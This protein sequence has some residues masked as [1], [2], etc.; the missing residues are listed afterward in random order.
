MSLTNWKYRL[1]LFFALSDNKLNYLSLTRL[2]KL[3]TEE[4]LSSVFS[5][6]FYTRDYKNGLGLRE[7]SRDMMQWLM[8]NFPLEFIKII[9]RIPYYGR[10]D[11]LYSLFPGKINLDGETEEI[12]VEFINRNFCSNICSSDLVNIKLCQKKIID[13]FVNQLTIDL[14]DMW[15]GKEISL[16][17]KWASSEGKSGDLNYGFAKT[18]YTN[19]NIS[20]RDYRK[21]LSSLRGSLNI[22]E[23]YTCKK[24]WKEIDYDCVPTCAKQKLNKAFLKHDYIRYRKF[25]KKCCRNKPKNL[26]EITPSDLVSYYSDININRITLSQLKHCSNPYVESVWEN[27]IPKNKGSNVVVLSTSGSF[28]TNHRKNLHI[29]TAIGLI[30]AKK[31]ESP[32]SNCIISHNSDLE[33]INVG[34]LLLGGIKSISN[35]QD[36]SS[37]D[38]VQLFQL[39]GSQNRQIIV[40]S[41]LE[42]SYS[43]KQLKELTEIRQIWG[44]RCPRLVYINL[45]SDKIE[46][47][48]I[49]DFITVVNGFLD[50]T[51]F[52]REL[53]ETDRFN[54]VNIVESKINAY[55]VKF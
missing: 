9:P 55:N 15:N 19:L 28:Y 18:M 23:N 29:A 47:I 38:L 12:I 39:V 48:E 42:F 16:A 45:N 26:E 24:L 40:V 25:I 1:E 2:L 4:D 43:N 20:P 27:L 46:F 41:H 17:S 22:V 51:E 30:L 32:F 5:L 11:D 31:S 36:N 49:N 21:L 54:P 7:I 33:I 35:I 52:Y 13:Y 34:K 37:I 50:K 3:C 44:D 14:D 6:L 10:W 8:I 53:V